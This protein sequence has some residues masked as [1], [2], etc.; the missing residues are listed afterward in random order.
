MSIQGLNN[1]QIN[2]IQDKGVNNSAKA[3]TKGEFANE[4]NSL[5]DKDKI[6]SQGQQEPLSIKFS[7]HA[8]E[9]MRSRGI[10]FSPE[11]LHR[12][13]GA[14]NKAAEKGAKETLVMASDSAM[15]VN[16]ENKTV[17]TVMDKSLLKENVFTNIDAAVMI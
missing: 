4:L 3:G 9:R 5:L 13:E 1:I 2:P 6:N 8:V 17:V 15:I 11:T 12:I 7:N 10:Y 14:V 16:V